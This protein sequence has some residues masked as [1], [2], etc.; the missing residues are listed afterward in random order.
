MCISTDGKTIPNLTKN[1]ANVSNSPG[2][3]TILKMMVKKNAAR[4]GQINGHYIRY[5]IL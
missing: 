1:D 2:K 5:I 3:S 4:E